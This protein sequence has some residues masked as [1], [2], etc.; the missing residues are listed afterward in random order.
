MRGE[1]LIYNPYIGEPESFRLSG[2]LENRHRFSFL[3][4][5]ALKGGRC[6]KLILFVA[7]AAAT[8]LAFMGGIVPGVLVTAGIAYLVWRA[9]TR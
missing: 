4:Y 5:W 2:E 6:M 1:K 7:A 3:P 9:N 8:A